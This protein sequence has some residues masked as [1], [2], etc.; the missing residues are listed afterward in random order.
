[1]T[2]QR[3]LLSIVLAGFLA[4]TAVAAHGYADL[5]TAPVP[6]LVAVGPASPGDLLE[7]C[8]FP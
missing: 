4:L 5:L 1:M 7:R 2:N 6:A 8:E 3:I